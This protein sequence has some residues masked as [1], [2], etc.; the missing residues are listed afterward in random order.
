MIALAAED[1]ADLRRWAICGAVVVL[2][3][4]GLAAGLV[5]WHEP[6][7][8]TG[9]AAGIVI[10]FA[11]MPVAPATV[12]SEVRPGPEM[13]TFDSTPTQQV[14]AKR[15]QK[16]EEKVESK[17]VEERPPE[18]PNPEAAIQP[19]EQVEKEAPAPQE[20]RPLAV[21]TAPQVVADQ[22]AALPAAPRQGAPNPYDSNAARTWNAQIVAQIQRN[23]RY[24][25]EARSR[26]QSGMARVVFTLDRQGRLVD[27]RVTNSSGVAVLDQEA[28]ALLR[29]APFPPAPP[30][31]PDERVTFNVLL[32]F[33]L[34]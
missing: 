34:K 32:N 22:L 28:L 13:D 7:E 15:E 25:S 27:S 21:A 1:L 31:L 23:K 33:G 20:Q 2:A 12:Q 24:P 9:A 19:P 8:G 6:V 4:G 29:R 26:S 16:V 18:V 30:G 14:E 3:Y 10:E 5:T 11:P 17:P